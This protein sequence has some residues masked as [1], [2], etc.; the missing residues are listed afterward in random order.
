M[1]VPGA[2]PFPPNQ[3]SRCEVPPVPPWRGSTHMAFIKAAGER[4]AVAPGSPGQAGRADGSG[5]VHP[6]S[7]HQTLGVLESISTPWRLHWSGAHRLKPSVA[8]RGC[9]VLNPSADSLIKASL[10]SF[11]NSHPGPCPQQGGTVSPGPGGQ[12]GASWL[13]CLLGLRGWFSSKTTKKSV[14]SPFPGGQ[15]PFLMVTHEEAKRTLS[16]SDSLSLSGRGT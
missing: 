1:H 9:F 7:G 6:F 13:V 10:R 12:S 16:L 15:M 3:I 4:P 8:K 5:G 11:V 14:T 2:R